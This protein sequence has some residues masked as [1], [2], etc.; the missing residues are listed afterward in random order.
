[1]KNIDELKYELVLRGF[2]II[3]DFEYVGRIQFN[4]WVPGLEAPKAL[5][6]S[7]SGLGDKGWVELL[8]G[9]FLV[10]YDYNDQGELNV[11]WHPDFNDQGITRSTYHFDGTMEAFLAKYPGLNKFKPSKTEVEFC[12]Y[13]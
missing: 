4:V 7:S 6:I 1:M 11:S 5:E 9:H 3:A 12:V 10:N 13:Y 2:E 8:N